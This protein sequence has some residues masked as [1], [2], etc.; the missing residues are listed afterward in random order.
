MS[1]RILFWSVT[2]G[3][4]CG[5]LRRPTLS[6]AHLPREPLPG[7]FGALRCACP[8]CSPF[9]WRSST[10]TNLIFTFVGLWLIDR[11]GRRALLYI[12]SYGYI[13]SLGL[14]AWAFFTEHY[15]IVP[16]AS[17]PSSPHMR[18]ARAR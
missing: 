5:R 12:G 1:R 17:S 11:L 8:S 15:T 4:Q 16:S 14:V 2:L 18:L 7:S 10:S 3:R 13:I 9:W 6:R